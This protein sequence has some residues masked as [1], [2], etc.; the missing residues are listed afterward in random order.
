[1]L[2]QVVYHKSDVQFDKAFQHIKSTS[3]NPVYSVPLNETSQNLG[4]D[5]KIS[6]A[7]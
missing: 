7:K 6:Y 1:M 4:K 2:L 3:F 5:E